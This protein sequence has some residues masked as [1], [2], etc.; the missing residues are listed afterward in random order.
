MFA[1]YEN[2]LIEYLQGGGHLGN[3]KLV[4]R[5]DFEGESY[6][7]YGIGFRTLVTK[8]NRMH[9]RTY[10]RFAFSKHVLR[11]VCLNYGV[12]HIWVAACTIRIID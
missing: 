2:K 7:H 3:I 8:P 12:R 1:L 5:V 6:G 10:T 4:G 9:A 11:V